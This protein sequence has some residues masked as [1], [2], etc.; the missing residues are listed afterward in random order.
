MIQYSRI[1]KLCTKEG[2]I[3]KKFYTIEIAGL[4]RDLQLFKI[5]DNLQIAAFILFGDVEITKASAKKLLEI[6]PEYDIL[7]TADGK[8]LPLIY[9]MA[10]QHGDSNYIV[11][12]KTP[13]LYMENVVSS[14]TKSITTAATQTLCIGQ[15]D[16]DAMKGKR[17]LI[18]DDVIS[19]GET[20]VSLEK[21]IN[22]AEGKI[23]GKMAI[24]AE[25]S[26]K[27]RDDI[28]YLA[29]LPLFDADNNPLS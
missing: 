1:E 10:A 2:L 5:S 4:K 27:D 11:A 13:K 25:G 29:P 8:S 16:M 26:A 6:A 14:A 3:L 24:L 21:L 28:T 22:A 23:V 15:S 18:V 19:T 12:R 17:V 20:L 7:I 9:E